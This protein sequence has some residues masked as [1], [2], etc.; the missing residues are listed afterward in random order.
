M[1]IQTVNHQAATPS[2]SQSRFHLAR[3]L[4]ANI[5]SAPLAL[6][7]LRGRVVQ[8]SILNYL[9]LA[10]GKTTRALNV[11]P[12]AT[13]ALLPAKASVTLTS[14]L[15]LIICLRTTHAV[16]AQALLRLATP[17]PKTRTRKNVTSAPMAANSVILPARASA[18]T[19][20]APMV[21][22]SC[23]ARN[24]VHSV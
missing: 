4:R 24:C 2:R 13:A 8:A 16:R 22:S 15:T 5:L 3:I 1:R 10:V 21:I 6:A 9:L 11:L 19:T 7:F 17:Y 14:A 20:S 18:P 12:I 23:Q